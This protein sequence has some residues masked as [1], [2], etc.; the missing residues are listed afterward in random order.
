MI[1]D[2]VNY[3]LASLYIPTALNL[4]IHGS[5]QTLQDFDYIVVVSASLVRYMIAGNFLGLPAV[6]VPVSCKIHFRYIAHK[7]RK[8]KI[9]SGPCSSS[10]FA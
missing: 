4:I 8:K 3:N 6:T 9:T 2:F 7:S 5:C 1:L 10:S